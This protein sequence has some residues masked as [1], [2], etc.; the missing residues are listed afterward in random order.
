M[1]NKISSNC[2]SFKEIFGGF[3]NFMN[4]QNPTRKNSIFILFE[5][6]II[7]L[8]ISFQIRILMPILFPLYLLNIKFQL[9]SINFWFLVIIENSK[10]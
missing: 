9:N 1:S 5:T 7:S 2:E 6:L 10:V 8:N 3:N 4:P